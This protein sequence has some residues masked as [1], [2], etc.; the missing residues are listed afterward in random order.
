MLHKVVGKIECAIFQNTALRKIR[1]KHCAADHLQLKNK[2]CCLCR[3]EEQEEF[4][5]GRGKV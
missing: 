2:W 5:G 3:G 1:E 4:H